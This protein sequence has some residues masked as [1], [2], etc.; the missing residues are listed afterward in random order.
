MVDRHP[1]LRTAFNWE[2]R[3]EPFQ[4]VYRRAELP[5]SRH[6]WRRVPAVEQ[7]RQ[8]EAFLGE[9]R[10]QGFELSKAPLMRLILVQLAE[11]TYQFIWSLH[12]LLLDGWSLHLLLQEVFQLYDACCAGRT[13]RWR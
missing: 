7:E 2:L 6:D 13:A 11:D 12:H 8:L 4:I 1:V 9:D 5:S 10:A 3:D